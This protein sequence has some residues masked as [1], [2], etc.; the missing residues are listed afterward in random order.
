[1]VRENRLP[2]TGDYEGYPYML[3]QSLLYPFFF[4][5]T[6]PEG[7]RIKLKGPSGKIIDG[8]FALV[9]LPIY[10]IDMLDRWDRAAADKPPYRVWY[11]FH[12]QG[13]NDGL[14]KTV[15]TQDYHLEDDVA[16][17]RFKRDNPSIEPINTWQHKGIP[18]F[19][20]Y[21][22]S[23]QPRLYREG[24]FDFGFINRPE[25][26]DSIRISDSSRYLP[27]AGFGWR[28]CWLWVENFTLPDGR[29]AEGITPL[30]EDSFLVDAAP[31]VYRCRLVMKQSDPA[32]LK[33]FVGEQ[34]VWPSPFEK[35]ELPSE[36]RFHAIAVNFT[37]TV[38]PD[39]QLELRFV[40]D[41][42]VVSIGDRRPEKD[43]VV[44]FEFEPA[45]D[46]A[47]GPPAWSVSE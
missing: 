15:G 21:A 2:T 3:R 42:K 7:W 16:I 14:A 11:V 6:F 23:F 28:H 25:Q 33:V 24:R 22:F 8:Y 1:M 32:Y 39:D 44:S 34:Q 37:T 30:S 13:V 27:W 29:E 31:G 18:N 17:D 26:P 46:K 47:A 35:P 36:N 45:A 43:L 19:I 20:A 40:P 41:M 9:G 4:Y 10:P 38:E 12:M 5:S